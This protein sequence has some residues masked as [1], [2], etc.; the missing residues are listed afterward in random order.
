MAIIDIN[1]EIIYD[2]LN[3]NPKTRLNLSNVNNFTT[4]KNLTELTITDGI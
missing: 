3:K 1:K 4:I 2:Y